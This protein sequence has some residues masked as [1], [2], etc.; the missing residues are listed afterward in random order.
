VCVTNVYKFLVGKNIG[1]L[2]AE[3]K[4]TGCLGKQEAPASIIEKK[5]K[6]SQVGVGKELTFY[7]RWWR[8]PRYL[9]GRTL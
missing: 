5:R 4:M 3:A 6:V 7:P 9:Y 2:Q 1:Q 8:F